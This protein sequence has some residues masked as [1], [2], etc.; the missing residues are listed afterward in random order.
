MA[1][2]SDKTG[3][4]EVYVAQFPS[5]ENASQEATSRA[6]AATAKSYSLWLRTER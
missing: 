2:T 3:Q 6:G 5:G 4:R 1:Y